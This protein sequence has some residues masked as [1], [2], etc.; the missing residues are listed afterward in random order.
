[1]P[2]R[3]DANTLDLFHSGG[4]GG[5]YRFTGPLS[6]PLQSVRANFPKSTGQLFVNAGNF[7]GELWLYRI[8]KIDNNGHLLG[9]IHHEFAQAHGCYDGPY[10]GGIAYSSN[11]GDTW[12]YLGDVFGPYH[13]CYDPNCNG[14]G[15]ATGTVAIVGQYFYWY[16]TEWGPNAQ[17]ED[18]YGISV[19]RAPVAEVVAAAQVGQTSPWFKYSGGGNFTG[20]PFT[21]VGVP[22][23][24]ANQFVTTNVMEPMNVTH[25]NALGKYIMLQFTYGRGGGVMAFSTDG[26]NWPASEVIQLAADDVA[27]PDRAAPCMPACLARSRGQR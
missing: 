19:L 1:V 14:T 18:R 9:F 3:R 25:S 4:C 15:T 26:L 10:R 20:N 7:P 13:P 21:G 6:A 17:T 12:T 22:V 2:L 16:F 8:Y 11:N 5:H 23:L 27:G 24:P